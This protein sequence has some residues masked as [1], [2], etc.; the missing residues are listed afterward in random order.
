MSNTDHISR[1]NFIEK[2]E[3]DNI[4]IKIIDSFSIPFYVK[5][6][7]KNNGIVV[8]METDNEFLTI[9]SVNG[10]A[11]YDVFFFNE[12]LFDNIMFLSIIGYY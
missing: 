4:Q 1:L 6:I 3:S 2:L 12:D 11:K 9:L 10:K 7:I 8:E 5:M